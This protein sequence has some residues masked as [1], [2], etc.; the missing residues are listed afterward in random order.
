MHHCDLKLENIIINREGKMKLIDFGCS[1]FT[2]SEYGERGFTQKYFCFE[3][4]YKETVDKY[5]IFAAELF[6]EI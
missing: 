3:I 4:F 5:D 2:P 1:T 6:S